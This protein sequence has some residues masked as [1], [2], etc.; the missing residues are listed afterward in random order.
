MLRFHLL[1]GGIDVAESNRRA[2]LTQKEMRSQSIKKNLQEKKKLIVEVLREI[3]GNYEVHSKRKKCVFV[4]VVSDAAR[5][6]EEVV[7]KLCCGNSD[8]SPSVLQ[9]VVHK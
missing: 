3:G 7:H 4:P 9:G 2:S 8:P 6:L 5:F 1:Q